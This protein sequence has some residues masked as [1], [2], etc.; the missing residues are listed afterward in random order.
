[1]TDLEKI[2][3]NVNPYDSTPPK[4]P[5]VPHSDFPELIDNTARE[6]YNLCPQKFF[7]STIQK[8]APDTPSIHL[9]F[10]GAYAAGLEAMRNAYYVEH[11]SERDALGVGIKAATV[12][13]GDCV[14]PEKSNKTYDALCGA[15]VSYV[16]EYPLSTDAVKPLIH[17]GKA[18]VEFTFATPIP[19]CYHPVTG[20]PL[21]YGGRFD[22]LGEFQSGNYVV[23]DKT[24]SQL[25]QS[26]NKQWELNSQ[27]TG[28]VW[29]AQQ[30]GIE[31]AGA[32]IRGQSIL[33]NGYGHA[34][35]II[36]RPQWQIDRWMDSLFEDV[37]NMIKDWEAKYYKYALGGACANYG[38]CE[39]LQLCNKQSPDE[40]IQAQYRIHL[41]N[42]LNKDPEAQ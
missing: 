14:P 22:F 11:Q 34:Q 21:L 42:P 17:N 25:G 30:S 20:N 18:A 36:Y 28:Y 4:E 23:D 26:W 1:M 9:H 10:G 15:L 33:K 6:Q 8:L 38:G 5:V 35:A 3:E 31:I 2:M 37:Q 29:G 32:I 24:T 39:F 41:W 40:W 7:R 19:S 13:F 27:F 12:F 16:D